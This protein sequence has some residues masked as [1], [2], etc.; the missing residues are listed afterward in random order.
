MKLFFKSLNYILNLNQYKRKIFLFLLDNLSILISFLLSL[1][2]SNN[3]ILNSKNYYSLIFLI[4][5]NS[6]TFL[7]IS[8]QYKSIIRYSG[9]N[10]FYKILI[11]NLFFISILFFQIKT[12]I[13]NVDLKALII[14]FILIS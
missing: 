4:I 9:S 3:E 1:W 7:F 6:V 8:N 5:I 11:N 12:L 10:E 14:F 2:L 13:F